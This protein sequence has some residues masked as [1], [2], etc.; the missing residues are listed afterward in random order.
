[1]LGAVSK[2]NL[3]KVA[4][5]KCELLENHLENWKNRPLRGQCIKESENKSGWGQELA[6]A[7]TRH[8]QEE[9]GRIYFCSSAT[10]HYKQM[11]LVQEFNLHQPASKS[12]PCKEKDGFAFMQLVDAP[13]LLRLSM[14]KV[15]TE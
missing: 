5:A 6:M 3:L 1:M 2:V 11:W 13:K 8:H 12:K 4:E 7:T 15:M 9:N 14:P 10:K